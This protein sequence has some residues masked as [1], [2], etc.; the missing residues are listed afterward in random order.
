MPLLIYQNLKGKFFSKK[1]S[2]FENSK[3]KYE[4]AN[5]SLGF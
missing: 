5:F 1:S 4:S 2:L 3:G